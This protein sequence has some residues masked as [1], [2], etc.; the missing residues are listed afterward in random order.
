MTWESILNI[1]GIAIP[2]TISFLFVVCPAIKKYFINKS[3]NLIKLFY[4][5]YMVLNPWLPYKEYQQKITSELIQQQIFFFSFPEFKWI[6]FNK[7][8]SSFDPFDFNNNFFYYNIS[9]LEVVKFYYFWRKMNKKI[10]YI[11]KIMDKYNYLFETNDNTLNYK[12]SFVNKIE[13]TSISFAPSFDSM[14]VNGIRIT[15]QEYFE[16]KANLME[17]YKKYKKGDKDRKIFIK[18]IKSSYF[19]INIRFKNNNENNFNIY[20]YSLEFNKNKNI[21]LKFNRILKLDSENEIEIKYHKWWIEEV[22]NQNFQK[23]FKK[24]YEEISFLKE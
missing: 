6:F 24:K 2:I 11:Y 14:R 9:F 16:E 8:K 17:Y 5:K 20:S 12:D 23:E 13:K 7:N 10:K 22:F 21:V 3:F 1:F 4:K 15:C 19:S 18:E